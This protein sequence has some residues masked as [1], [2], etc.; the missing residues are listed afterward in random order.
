M[1]LA[2]D[3]SFHLHTSLVLVIGSKA[4]FWV[5][6]DK[7]IPDVEIDIALVLNLYC[8]KSLPGKY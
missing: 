2:F 7:F 6:C 8:L 5:L 3:L 1:L 4:D